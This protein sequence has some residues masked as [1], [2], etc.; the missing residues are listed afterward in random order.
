MS[1]TNI[2]ELEVNGIIY[3]PKSATENKLYG[4]DYVLIRTFSAGVH[5]GKLM[6]QNGKEVVLSNSR[7]V[8]Y[9]DGACSLSQ[10]AV[11]G[12]SKPDNCKFSVIVPEITLTEAIEIIPITEKAFNNLYSVLE[13][14]I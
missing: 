4:D 2:N 5:F 11:D 10:M 13:W 9:W 8:Y 7:R 6:A 14:K 1:K 3:V 12:V